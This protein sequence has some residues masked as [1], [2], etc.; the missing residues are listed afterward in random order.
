VTPLGASEVAEAR[1]WGGTGWAAGVWSPWWWPRCAS[2]RGLAALAGL[3]DVARAQAVGPW[4]TT[5][6][7]LASIVAA[8]A[9]G[10]S[11]HGGR[12]GAFTAVC[13]IVLVEAITNGLQLSA[14]EAAQ[15]TLAITGLGA[16]ALLLDVLIRRPR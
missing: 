6:L 12:G 4:P 15:V 9:G 7:G 10:A 2:R 5:S 11:V 13:G 8:I 3:A 1:T 14:A 16:A